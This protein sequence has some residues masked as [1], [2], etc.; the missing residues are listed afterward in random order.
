[1]RE[2]TVLSVRLVRQHLT[3]YLGCLATIVATAALTSAEAGL[4]HGSLTSPGC[5][6]RVSQPKKLP[7]SYPASEA[8]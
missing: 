2:L 1:M 6:L 4:V 8:F 3:L 5:T 7:H